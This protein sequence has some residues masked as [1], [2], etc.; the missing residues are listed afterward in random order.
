MLIFIL[1][2][3]N[4]YSQ[5]NNYIYTWYN[6][7]IGTLYIDKQLLESS[8][9][10][11][12]Q[13]FST[14]SQYLGPLEPIILKIL[15]Y[16]IENL[17]I[18]AS[19]FALLFIFRRFLNIFNSEAPE[20][21]KFVISALMSLVLT[22][23]FWPFVI[24]ILIIAF[25]IKI[26]RIGKSKLESF[27]ENLGKI[28]AGLKGIFSRSISDIKYF[29]NDTY[30]IRKDINTLD[31]IINYPPIRN[32]LNSIEKDI[33]TLNNII[34]HLL[35]ETENEKLTP[36]ILT[37]YSSKFNMIYNNAINKIKQLNR[38][39][40]TMFSNPLLLRR[41]GNRIFRTNKFTPKYLIELRNILNDLIARLNTT[42]KEGQKIFEDLN[43]LLISAEATSRKYEIEIINTLKRNLNNNA[44]LYLG[45][46][47][48]A[49]IREIQKIEKTII[50]IYND[51][52]IPSLLKMKIL[53]KMDKFTKNLSKFLLKLRKF[54]GSQLKRNPKMLL[55]L[56]NIIRKQLTQ[57]EGSI[58]K[59]SS[60][61]Y[62]QSKRS[63]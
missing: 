7:S 63:K 61:S 17:P 54:K 50:A 53:F 24:P 6:E 46:N 20:S 49:L 55:K 11:L 37:A 5:S 8:A 13:Y 27:K 62:S 16:L 58:N 59:M 42:Y 10:M 1:N 52:R 44:L 2:F 25:I 19:F 43:R 30:K 31:K 29:D 40:N 34:F 21:Q 14:L 35:K 36:Y 38:I 39:I 28:N 26:F 33:E 32:L 4:I 22:Y 47:N 9:S 15:P 48:K 12:S 45:N 3:T 41:F 23:F 51:Q 60:L 56:T 57:L 18:L